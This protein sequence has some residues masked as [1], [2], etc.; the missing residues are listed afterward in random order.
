MYIIL[1][2]HFKII[3]SRN[4]FFKNHRNLNSTEKYIFEKYLLKRQHIWETKKDMKHKNLEQNSRY[5]SNPTNNY[6]KCE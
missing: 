2:Q 1:D 5:K 4:I 6:I 3:N